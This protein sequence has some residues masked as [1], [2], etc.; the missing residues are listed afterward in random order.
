M[1]WT[2]EQYEEYKRRQA[3]SNQN[4][5]A[6]KNIK[7]S[8]YGTDARIPR[9]P[10]ESDHQIKFMKELKNSDKYD[11]VTFFAR[12]IPNGEYRDWK[13]GKLL[14]DMGVVRGVADIFIQ[15]PN[16][17]GKHGLFIEFKRDKTCVQSPDQERFQLECAVSGYE[18]VV[19]Y[20]DLEAYN[21]LCSYEPI[22][23]SDAQ[24]QQLCELHDRIEASRE[25]EKKR[26]QK[27]KQLKKQLGMSPSERLPRSLTK[28][29]YDDK[30]T[31]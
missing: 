2:E 28:Q 10:K 12:H 17:K 18:Y 31:I 16:K 13:T 20:N 3:A 4:M 1:N 30:R 27:R 21:V 14:K 19:V 15:L 29:L 22:K 26:E 6:N 23:P 8:K 9:T 24:M 5:L 25:N 7:T 11:Y